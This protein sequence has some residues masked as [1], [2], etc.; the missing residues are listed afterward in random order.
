MP[1]SF[2]KNSCHHR[3]FLRYI[4]RSLESFSA[5]LGEHVTLWFALTPAFIQLIDGTEKPKIPPKFAIR[6]ARYNE[7][8]CL[9]FIAA[10][11]S[12][13]WLVSSFLTNLLNW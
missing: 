5:K 4:L 9:K 13:P 8:R 2:D 11:S 3:D 12:Y 6:A 10:R 7:F 1:P